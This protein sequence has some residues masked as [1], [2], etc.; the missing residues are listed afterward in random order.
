MK[1]KI[2]KRTRINQFDDLDLEVAC[3][4]IHEQGLNFAVDLDNTKLLVRLVFTNDKQHNV[5]RKRLP[6]F[7]NAPVYLMTAK[8]T[9]TKIPGYGHLYHKDTIKALAKFLNL[10]FSKISRSAWINQDRWDKYKTFKTHIEGKMR[11]DLT[12]SNK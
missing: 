6:H 10:T 3:D 8:G 7:A 9:S 4:Y 11:M 5:L 1:K 2:D 12:G